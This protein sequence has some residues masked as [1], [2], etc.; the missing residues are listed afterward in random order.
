M[1]KKS[2]KR[3]P[4]AM[5][6]PTRV[7]DLIVFAQTVHD[8]MAANGT[9]L[10]A[11]SPVLLMFQTDINTLVT[12][13]ALVK[14][15]MPGAVN[16]RDAAVKAV[17][18]DLHS[19]RAYV[20]LVVNADPAN[21]ANIAEAAGMSLRKTPVIDKPPLAVKAVAS[22]IVKLVAKASK[23]AKANNWQMSTDGGKTW[24]DLPETT[25]ASTQVANLTP[26]T[27]VHFRQ[28]PV[29]KAGASEWSL[30]VPH[31]VQ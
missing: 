6:P 5:R 31:L 16:D 24:V 28:R 29:T 9:L 14:A 30:P 10:P 13:E 18:V 1:G 23:G 4:V 15:K 8:K 20:E 22:G 2:T 11:P 21:A 17:K 12:K 27:T 3:V 19:E 7:A 26:A 25:K